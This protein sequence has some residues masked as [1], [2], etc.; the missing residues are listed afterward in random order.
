MTRR[1]TQHFPSGFEFTLR[2]DRLDKPR[3][4]R[5]PSQMFVDSMSDLF[6][7]R[8]PVPFF[9]EVFRVLAE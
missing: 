9:E 1:F 8:M 6:H 4:W 7:E 5:K 3:R 2:P